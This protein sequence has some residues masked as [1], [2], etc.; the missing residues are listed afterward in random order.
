MVAS[1]ARVFRKA[2]EWRFAKGKN[3]PGSTV[4]VG[5]ERPPQMRKSSSPPVRHRVD[6]LNFRC[7]SVSNRRIP[8]RGHCRRGSLPREVHRLAGIFAPL[9]GFR[10]TGQPGPKPSR[11]PPLDEFH[12]SP[13]VSRE[14][15]NRNTPERKTRARHPTSQSKEVHFLPPLGG[16]RRLIERNVA[17]EEVKDDSSFDVSPSGIQ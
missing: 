3:L 6:L 4:R 8:E 14:G 11:R 9:P 1:G 5:Q 13:A 10:G 16:H 7:F 17:H 12:A 2:Y 15:K